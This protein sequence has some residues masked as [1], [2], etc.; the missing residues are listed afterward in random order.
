MI[1]SLC[2]CTVRHRMMYV[3]VMSIAAVH[4]RYKSELRRMS[5]CLHEGI[6]VAGRHHE[7]LGYSSG[8]VCTLKNFDMGR[9]NFITLCK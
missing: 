4:C 2:C 8:Q 3:L 7:L 5:Q 9:R 6:D 1:L